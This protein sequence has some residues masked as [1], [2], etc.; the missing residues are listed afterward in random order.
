MAPQRHFRVLDHAAP[1]AF[2]A[3]ASMPSS[4]TGEPTMLD[5][6]TAFVGLMQ[7]LADGCQTA[8]LRE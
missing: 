8:A 4:F 5:H 7:R 3:S 6:E 2:A 1:I